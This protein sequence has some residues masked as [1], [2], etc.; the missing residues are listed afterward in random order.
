MRL[1]IPTRTLEVMIEV[2]ELT[3]KYG[4]GE[5]AVTAV[6][7]VTFTVRPGIVT[8]FLGPNGA[9]KSTTMRSIL[10]LDRPTS[11][12][13][14]VN[15][16]EFRDAPAPLSELGALLEAKAIT[17]SRSRPPSASAPGGW[18]RCSTWSGSPR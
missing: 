16:R 18:T 5:K 17:C 11:G 12:T 14:T 1:S 7:H 13:A 3:K 4:S 2:R 9:G 15:G 8:G 6:D 10:G